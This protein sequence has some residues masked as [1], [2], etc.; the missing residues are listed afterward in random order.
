MR[1]PAAAGGQVGVQRLPGGAALLGERQQPRVLVLRAAV[2]QDRDRAH[3]LGAAER[4]RG[5]SAGSRPVDLIQ[6]PVLVLRAA[7]VQDR[8]RAHALG[9]AACLRGSS[10]GMKPRV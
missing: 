5:T 8:D 4:L 10:A 1:R 9:A 7:V 6:A 3:A 2:V